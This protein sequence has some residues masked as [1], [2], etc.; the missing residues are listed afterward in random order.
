MATGDTD[1]GL[2]RRLRAEVVEYLPFWGE[3]L[4]AEG[5][6][7]KEE[8]SIAVA[9]ASAFEHQLH[10][11]LCAGRNSVDECRGVK[12]L[13]Q[14]GDDVDDALSVVQRSPRLLASHINM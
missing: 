9:I 13:A 2:A 8:K 10:R 1:V 3:S 6:R 11:L 4:K 14:A 7:R 12:I 5:R